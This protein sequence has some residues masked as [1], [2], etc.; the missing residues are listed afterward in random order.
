[1]RHHVIQNPFFFSIL[2]SCAHDPQRSADLDQ[3]NLFAQE[4]FM[5]EEAVSAILDR[6]KPAPG[7]LLVPSPCSSE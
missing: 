4:F 1:M 5:A 2:R 3:I 6:Q 7:I